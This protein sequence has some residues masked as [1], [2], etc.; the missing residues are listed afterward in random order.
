MKYIFL[1]LSKLFPYQTYELLLRLI[2]GIRSYWLIP[3]FKTCGINSRFERIGKIIG[4]KYISI[5]NY[6]YFAEGFYITV[7]KKDKDP[8]LIIGNN[9]AFGKD[10]HITCSNEIRIGDN[11]LTGK[12][13]TITD[14]SHGQ[15]DFDSLKLPPIK[16]SVFSKGPVI[17]G[18][19]VWIGE[20]ATVLPGI[21][22]GKAATIA[23]NVV[24]TIYLQNLRAVNNE[25]IR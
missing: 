12:W 24:V 10:N 3:Q 9:C 11:L 22:F 6:T 14:N 25:R 20:K 21:T 7:W 2:R 17:I 15:T 16:R 1:L 19:N 5:G 8:L 23:A 4:Q 18:D 13:V